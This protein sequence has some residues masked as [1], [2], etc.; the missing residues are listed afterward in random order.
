MSKFD[1]ENDIRYSGCD[2]P[3][4]ALIKIQKILEEEGLTYEEADMVLRRAQNRVEIGIEK[5]KVECLYKA[6]Y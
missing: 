2:K 4:R 1:N 3:S 5:L 6:K